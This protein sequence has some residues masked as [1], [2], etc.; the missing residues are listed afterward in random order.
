VERVEAG[1]TDDTETEELLR[2]YLTPMME[3]G[4]D[5]LVLGC[6]HYPFLRPAI[7]SA[8]ASGERDV[9]VIDPTP[10]V[11]RQ[12]GRV[13]AGLGKTRHN[14]TGNVILFTSGDVTAFQSPILR[15]ANIS[16]SLLEVRW[17]DGEIVPQGWELRAP[18]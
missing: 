1:K 8:L 12:A 15:L 10:A 18:P 7:D 17:V 14:G 5:S 9:V 3:A 16:G 13:L 6:T 4:I 11:A 2:Q